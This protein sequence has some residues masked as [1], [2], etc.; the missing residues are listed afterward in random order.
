MTVQDCIKAF[1]VARRHKSGRDRDGDAVDKKVKDGAAR[2][3]SEKKLEC[4]LEA[5][6]EAGVPGAAETPAGW[7]E[8][9]WTRTSR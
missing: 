9:V 2:V 8:L 7:S 5:L 1:R 4:C 6:A 3:L